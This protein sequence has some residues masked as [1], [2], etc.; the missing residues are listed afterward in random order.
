[1]TQAAVR[2]QD[3]LDRPEPPTATKA[4]LRQVVTWLGLAA[5]IASAAVGSNMFSVRDRLLGS[6]LPEPVRPVGSRVA[7]AE[8]GSIVAEPTAL[9]SA[10]WWQDVTTIE[11]LEAT[12]SSFTVERSAIQ[13]RVTSS[14]E[15]GRLLVRVPGEPRALIDAAC[16]ETIVAYG[17]RTGATTVEVSADGPWRLQV[18]QQID[19]PLVEPP[20]PGMTSPGATA[21]ATGTFY[22]LDRTAVGRVTIFDQADGRYTVRLDDFFVS[23]DAQ[24]QLRLSTAE[25]PKTSAEYLAGR[26]QLLT[27]LDVTAGSLNYLPPVGVDP[28]EFRS[29]VIW[30]PPTNSAFAAAT[31]ETAT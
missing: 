18:A 22:K 13:W 26:S 29:V 11:G 15:S 24:L 9:R 23:P 16:S 31:L 5:L 6:A 10:P 19:T 27:V 12:T 4:A 25:E 20:L 3:G 30:R 17:N 7:G 1:M 21:I 14:C 8:A 2:T 28:T